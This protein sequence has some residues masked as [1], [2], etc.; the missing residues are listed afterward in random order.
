MQI[1]LVANG[2]VKT[3]HGADALAE[4]I[5][6]DGVMSARGIL[7]NPG[8]FAGYDS[9]PLKCVQ[10]WV[11]IC[12]SVGEEAITFQ[13]FHHHL[14]FMMEKLMK[15]KTRVLF[16][17][18]TK[19]EEVMQFLEQEYGIRR[20]GCRVD[21]AEWAGHDVGQHM[22]G[23]FDETNYKRRVKVANEIQQR[24]EERRYDAEAN[25][26]KFFRSKIEADDDDEETI[27]MDSNLF[28]L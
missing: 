3:L 18:F 17:S 28:D 21:A 15:R 9:T 12:E 8:L 20:D 6:C 2:D 14:T 23:E 1:P 5:G 25:E 7:A 11:D 19:R 24:A 4:R 22:R 16:N 27:F 13:C 26:G 10:D